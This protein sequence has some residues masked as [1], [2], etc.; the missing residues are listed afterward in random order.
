MSLYDANRAS[1]P[2]WASFENPDAQPNEGAKLNRGA[3]GRP[4]IVLDAGETVTLMRAQGS[5]VVRRIW[6]TI[7]DRE[8]AALRSVVLRMYWDGAEKPAVECPIADFFGFGLASMTP[9]Q[10]ELFSS[11]EGRSFNCFVPM[12][13]YTG[14]KI[15]LENGNDRG[16]MLFYDVDFTLEPLEAGKA[17][18]FHAWW[19]RENPTVLGR[20]YTILAPVRGHGRFLGAS[21]G[22]R[23]NTALYGATWFGEG[24]VKMYLDGDEH[25]TLCGTGTE[26]YIGDA[27][28]QGPFVNMTQGCLEGSFE[29]GRFQF[30]RWHTVDPIYFQQDLRVTIHNMGNGSIEQVKALQDSGAPLIVTNLFLDNVYD[31]DRP[32]VLTGRE[33]RGGVNFYRQD[34]YCSVA[35]FYLD[36]PESG[37]PSLPGKDVRT[38]DM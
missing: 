18:Y 7:S 1:R 11:P 32:Y 12:P 31:P 14:A 10:S 2:R 36:R 5:G 27:W 38:A 33:E 23:A 20:E 25:P 13:F 6:I 28:G 9:Y 26:D 35:Y 29:T 21:V 16:F 3:K 22:V 19:N 34:D 37:L 8:S 30:Y 4:A 24:E 15:T 17:L